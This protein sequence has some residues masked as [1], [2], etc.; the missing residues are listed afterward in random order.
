MTELQKQFL[1][2]YVDAYKTYFIDGNA[3]EDKWYLLTKASNNLDKHFA[4]DEH[5]TF[6]KGAYVWAKKLLQA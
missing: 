5:P 2:E 3:T 4:K 1:Q 6:F